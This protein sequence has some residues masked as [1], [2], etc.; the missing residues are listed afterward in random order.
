M[1]ITTRG[2]LKDGAA[3]P[4]ATLRIERTGKD[5]LV[6]PVAGLIGCV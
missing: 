3:I 1:T 5:G 2:D 6:L 4:E